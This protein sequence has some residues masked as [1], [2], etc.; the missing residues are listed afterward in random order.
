[1]LIWQL[2]VHLAKFVLKR[3]GQAFRWDAGASENSQSASRSLKKWYI[4]H[5]IELL[6]C[7]VPLRDV[8][9]DTNHS[10]PWWIFS[11][12]KQPKTFAYRV[13]SRPILVCKPLI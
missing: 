13:F 9:R 2:R 11:I 4:N 10:K 8:R 5:G 3:H 6:S 1:M 12:P 7:R